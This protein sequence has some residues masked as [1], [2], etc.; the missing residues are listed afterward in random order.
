VAQRIDDYQGFN[1]LVGDGQSLWYLLGS[2]ASARIPQAL[3]PGIYG[4]S[5]AALDVPWPKVRRARDRLAD[6]LATARPGV[7]DEAALLACV[8]N[9]DLA[10]GEELHGHGLSGDMA[11]PLSAQFIVTPTYG[12][13]C[14]TTLISNADGSILFRERRY[15]NA[16]IMRGEDQFL[17]EAESGY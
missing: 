3:T 12:T 11:R 17:I 6:T 8:H 5:N 16:G 10:S 4:L 9:R 2:D 15:D 7:P 1:L 14:S 13:R